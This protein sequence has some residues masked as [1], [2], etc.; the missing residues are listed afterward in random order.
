VPVVL[1][2]CRTRES[3]KPRGSEK[4]PGL[5][6]EHPRR[7]GFTGTRVKTPRTRLHEKHRHAP[8]NGR[9]TVGH[10]P[11]DLHLLRHLR[12]GLPGAQYQD[13]T[14]PGRLAAPLRVLLAPAST[15][16]RVQAIDLNS[17]HETKRRG[18]YRHP[19]LTVE[20]MKAR[21][22]RHERAAPIRTGPTQNRRARI[23]ENYFSLNRVFIRRGEQPLREGNSH[24]QTTCNPGGIVPA[25]SRAC[26]YGCWGGILRGSSGR[27]RI[28]AR[29]HGRSCNRWQLM[30]GMPRSM[31]H[32]VSRFRISC[33]QLVLPVQLLVRLL[34]DTPGVW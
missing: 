30:Y 17:L 8:G 7:P 14:G 11:P 26:R 1:R 4:I 31:Q 33:Y 23:A 15:S 19:A 16:A 24:G 28:P 5:R 34:P 18:R 29:R 27:S 21:G 12:K 32:P 3:G 10:P 25:P 2:T 22:R 9:K 13:G 6:E 20:D